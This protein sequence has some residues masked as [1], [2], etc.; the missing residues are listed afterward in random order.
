MFESI[1][2]HLKH[3]IL[4]EYNELLSPNE[5]ERVDGSKSQ[6]TFL[7]LIFISWT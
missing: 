1:V 5:M 6:Y 7:K 4:S 2:S 3:F